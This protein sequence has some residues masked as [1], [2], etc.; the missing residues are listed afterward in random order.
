VPRWFVCRHFCTY[1]KLVDLAH[2]QDVEAG[3]GT[4]TVTILAGSL[5]HGCQILL[6]KGIHPT[7]VAEGLQ[8]AAAV[9]VEILR[10]ISDPVRTSSLPLAYFSGGPQRSRVLVEKC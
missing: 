6:D 10:S 5:L 9:A 2:A 3:D 1:V 4:T 8:K 7:T